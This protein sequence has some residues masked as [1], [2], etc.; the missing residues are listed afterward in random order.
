MK[1]I[2]IKLIITITIF[3]Q[4]SY[5]ASNN[6]QNGAI[7][8]QGFNFKWERNLLKM[9][10]IPHRLGSFESL[11]SNTT[12]I[13]SNSK[14]YLKSKV[15]MYFTPGVNGDFSYPQNF[16]SILFANNTESSN[17]FYFDEQKAQLNFSDKINKTS[18]SA[19][20]FN[21]FKKSFNNTLRQ[22]NLQ[23][24]LNGFSLKMNC[25]PTKG[26]CNSEGIW[27][28]LF[29]I[30]ILSCTPTLNKINCEFEFNLGRGSAPNGGT[31]K[32]L[33][34]VMNYQL[35]LGLLLI[36]KQGKTLKFV[37]H[38]IEQENEIFKK[39]DFLVKNITESDNENEKKTVGITGFEFDL[40][41]G[42]YDD[43]G[44][45]LY[46][47][48]FGVRNN[49]FDK[50]YEYL[51]SIYAPYLTTFYSK[52]NMKMFTKVLYLEENVSIIQ[53]KPAKGKICVSD[54][55]T[56]FWCK[57]VGLKEQTYDSKDIIYDGGNI[58]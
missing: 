30:N 17:K 40:F 56:A 5:I 6:L 52:V 38:V 41:G 37:D 11:F 35:E 44:R 27:P 54:W 9:F 36:Y 33:S 32:P 21:R 2:F 12:T 43:K 49:P 24:V 48:A 23:V 22:T 4:I 42:K 55:T 15:S 16:Y 20:S 31:G 26:K 58:K 47:L 19:F 18:N 25:D 28:H 13:S 7:L 14:N 39:N 8:W 57:F 1:T 51:S 29:K 50:K 3:S 34:E 10:E 53:P 46:Q 45:Y